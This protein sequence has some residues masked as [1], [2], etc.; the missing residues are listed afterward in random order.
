MFSDFA[1]Q[2]DKKNLDRLSLGFFISRH[3]NQL[4]SVKSYQLISKPLSTDFP[5]LSV[6]RREY[7]PFAI[8]VSMS[9][10]VMFTPFEPATSQD[11]VTSP[12]SF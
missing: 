1:R 12:F 9:Q 3:T 6:R 4:M 11:L 8:E 2:H 5:L 7:L 10:E